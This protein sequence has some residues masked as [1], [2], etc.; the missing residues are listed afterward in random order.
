MTNLLSA[1]KKTKIKTMHSQ[2]FSV[3]LRTYLERHGT[4]EIAFAET[5]NIRRETLARWLSGEVSRPRQRED[6]MRCATYLNLNAEERNTLLTAAGFPLEHGT[7]YRMA[8]PS[9][10]LNLGAIQRSP[11]I[12][13]PPITE[14][15]QFFGRDYVLKRIFDVWKCTPLQHIAIVGLKRSGKTSLLH[16]L[17]QI[18]D[19]PSEELRAGQRNDWL[20]PGY[21]WIFVDFQDPRMCYQESLLRHLLVEMNMPVPE[22]CDLVSFMEIIDQYL[23]TPTLI[24]LD[25]ISAGLAATDLDEQFWWGLRSL[26]SNHTNGKLGF[27]LTA[28]QAPE[29]MAMDNNKPSPFFNIFGHVLSL[30]ALTETEALALIHSSPLPFPEDDVAWIMAQSGLWPAL[31]QILCH[32]RLTA[33]QENQ[34]NS[35]W[36][37]EGLKRMTP[38]RYLLTQDIS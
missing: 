16:Y 23:T 8:T 34:T 2:A 31:L 28:H 17:R 10:S 33:L 38:Y 18:I 36:Q 30:G 37:T 9:L 19:T 11:F 12:I 29:E 4:S 26:G 7:S 25:E 15:R 35:A 5:L 27:L 6:V 24:L 3:L 1:V 22:P 20:V 14:P 32:A 13:G 21:Q